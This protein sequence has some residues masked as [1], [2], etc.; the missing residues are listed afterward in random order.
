MSLFRFP[1]QET[2]MQSANSFLETKLAQKS[3]FVSI[4]FSTTCF[5]SDHWYSLYCTYY[6]YSWWF[7]HFS[8]SLGLSV[9][10]FVRI[11]RRIF[12]VPLYFWRFWFGPRGAGIRRFWFKIAR[13]ENGLEFGVCGVSRVK[14]GKFRSFYEP[15]SRTPLTQQC[16]THT[17]VLF[18]MNTHL[19]RRS[20]IRFSCRYLRSE[21]PALSVFHI[22]DVLKS[23]PFRSMSALLFS[24]M[25]FELERIQT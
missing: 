4:V 22:Y 11:W 13:P 20:D 18:E 5:N 8:N 15:Q 10:P 1:K 23:A 19:I 16:S 2:P 24:L 14:W 7:V 17:R 6:L 12:D 21:S 9:C 25:K 3:C